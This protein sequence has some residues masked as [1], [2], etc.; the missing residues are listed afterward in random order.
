MKRRGSTRFALL[1]LIPAALLYL[2]IVVLPSLRAFGYSFQKWNGFGEIKFVGTENFQKLFSDPLFYAAL[3]HNAFLFVAGGSITLAL[4]LV[5]ANL[6]HRGVR[7]AGMFRVAFFFPNV[8]A[9]VAVASLW[10]LIYSPSS[11]GVANAVLLQV[12]RLLEGAGIGFMEG[13]LPFAFAGSENLLVSII[14]M[15]VWMATGFYMVLFLAAME[16]IPTELYEAAKLDGATGPRQFWHV[17]LPLVREVLV[18][19]IVFFIISSA[20]FFDAIWVMNN[21]YPTPDTHVLATVLYQ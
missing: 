10:M 8:I 21:E 9:S 3:K 19:G 5:F 12:Q 17:T 1:C 2:P 11:Y 16:S 18:V 15:L 4:A 14:P 20:K 7:G 13:K 6:L